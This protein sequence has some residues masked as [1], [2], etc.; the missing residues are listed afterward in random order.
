M[1]GKAWKNESTKMAII[2]DKA[3]GVPVRIICERY[4]LDASTVW[5][6][7][8]KVQQAHPESA[9]SRDATSADLRTRIKA[10]AYSALE[11]GLDHD[12]DPYKRASIGVK[13]LEG[14]G[15]FISGHQVQVDG[16]V[17]M[18]VSWLPIQEPATEEALDV[19]TKLISD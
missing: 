14:I 7:C 17:S 15:E 10:K 4:N 18:T 16:A 9:I 1:P 3:A 2:A 11:G 13:V 6:I 12:A 5:R 8:K 19:D